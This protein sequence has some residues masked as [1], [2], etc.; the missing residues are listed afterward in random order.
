MSTI[1]APPRLNGNSVVPAEVLR[2]AD[3]LQKILQIR[4]EVLAS[5]HPRIHLPS[6]VI[7]QVAPRLPQTTLPNRPT[8]NGASNG[9]HASQLL[10]PRPESSRQ[11]Y[12]SANELVSPVPPTQ[13]PYS[14]KS[15]SSSIDPVLL[16]KSDHLIRAELQLKR[17][18][19]ERLLKDQFDKKGRGN[20]LEERETHVDVEKCLIEAQIRIPP[21]SGLQ[22][23]TNNSDGVESFD[24]NSYYSSKADSWSS[25]EIDPKQNANADPAGPF[26]PQAKR[27]GI[28]VAAQSRPVEPTVIDLDEEL[29]E[30][31]DDIEIYEP[32]PSGLLETEEEDYSPPPADVGPSETNRGRARDRG[33]QRNGGTNG[34]S[35]QQS[36]V[37][38]AAPL[39]N[40]RKRRRE[41]KRRQ[42][43]AN[44]RVARSPEPYI[45]EEPPSPPHFPAY[46]DAPASKRRAL[47]PLPNDI[48]VVTPQE[49]ARMQPV[50]YREPASAPRPYRDYEE[51]SSPT[52][53]RVPQRRPQR[54]DDL[55]RVASLQ[56]ARMPYSPVGGG[57]VYA[58]PEPRPIRAASH[59]FVDRPEQPVYR[60]A[61]VRPSA[62]PRY[63]HERSRSPIHEYLPQQQSPMIMAPPPRRI[64]VDQYGN[65]YYAAPVDARESA[66]PPSRRMEVDPFYERA[67][68]R[69]PTMRAPARTEMYE[70]DVQ[71]MP[72]PPPRR[73][74]EASEPE[75]ID[76]RLYRPREASRRPVEMEYRPQEVIERRSVSQYEEMGPP[77][78]YM[79][80]RAY[81]VR[82][83]VIRREVP[84]GY[85]RHESVQPG[86]VRAS[87]PHYRE[88]SIVHQEP[89]DD[90]RFMYSAP[91]PQGRR[92]VED[93]D[94]VQEQ[95]AAPPRQ[96]Y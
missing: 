36:P 76:S 79:S 93:G 3:F 68:T 34:S 64:V 12:A 77:R 80:S 65:K 38:P 66:A 89:F 55:R 60:E 25:E 81:S 70:E 46:A 31:A 69:E 33:N 1:A 47:Q 94:V 84:E 37:G 39:N 86:L 62:A 73:Y 7:E 6:K 24:E 35:R 30:P 91:A 20:D 53:I 57:D 29:Y 15:V 32:E 61:S 21:V 51:L 92:Y 10:P 95:Y 67:V 28:Q 18:Q 9:I 41:E 5:K 40:P 54:D 49:S 82:P 74:V 71:M 23:T 78:E 42:Q 8:T 72:P 75:M 17:Q 83:E 4:D 14:A 45:K 58:A 2:E 48:E 90:R 11:Q 27:S 88:V 59:A 13:R 43:Q 50:Y 56:H 16:T 85:V 22:S 44:K 63:M 96:R 87:Q 19:I 26:T 52:V